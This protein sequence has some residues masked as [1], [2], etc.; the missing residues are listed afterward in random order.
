VTP[1]DGLTEDMLFLV[2]PMSAFKCV[3]M[4]PSEA[5]TFRTLFAPL[6]IL[7]MLLFMAQDEFDGS[8]L[9]IC[10]SARS[11]AHHKVGR[12]T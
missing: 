8:L 7:E 11:H 4:S 2:S 10:T 9:M 1:D 5:N 12:S 6:D 3:A